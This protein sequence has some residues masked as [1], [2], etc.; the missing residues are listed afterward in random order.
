MT[1][2]IIITRLRA[3]LLSETLETLARQTEAPGEVIVVDNAGCEKTRRVAG[4]FSSRFPVRYVLEPA[5]GYGHARNRG[6]TEARGE[7]IYFLDDDCL[8]PPEW[9]VRLRSAIEQG[10]ADV[11]GGSRTSGRTGLAARL[12]YLSTDGPVLHPGLQRGPAS[13]LSTSNLV[14][15]RQVAEA[16]GPFDETLAMCEDR[17]FTVRARE[18]GFRLLF[19]PGVRV[20]HQPPIFTLKQYHAKMRHYGYGTSQY[21][22]R[23]RRLEP[24]A[25]IFPRAAW[26]RL[27]LLPALSLA[28]AGYLV[29]RNLPRQPDALWLSP[30]LWTGQL[31]W[32]WGGYEA[33]REGRC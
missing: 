12:E 33:M 3:E 19:E 2:V 24:L 5:T 11:V 26:A 21:F 25:R 4:E 27:L 31:C 28:G 20:V 6:L 16:V 17:D 13:H 32:H 9:L 23:W 15:R 29:L 10:E 1:S 30:L 14:L 8:A 7:W 22:V 18:A